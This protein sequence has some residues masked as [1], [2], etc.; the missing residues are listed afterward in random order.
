MEPHGISRA[1][2]AC[3]SSTAMSDL[4]HD[5]YNA[6]YAG[7]LPP[8]G[9]NTIEMAAY[10][11]GVQESSPSGGASGGGPAGGIMLVTIPFLPLLL[12]VLTVIYPLPG[13]MTFVAGAMIAGVIDD[14]RLHWLMILFA[15]TV[16]CIAVFALAM[17]LEAKLELSAGY[18]LVRHVA[19]AAAFAFIVH[20]FVFAARGAGHF[21]PESSLV[22][23]LSL[24][25][26]LIVAGAFVVG[27]FLS[28]LLDRRLGRSGRIMG[29]LKWRKRGPAAA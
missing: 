14:M 19:R 2:L 1:S 21:A 20:I 17:R 16:P 29:R 8:S 3:R 23:R 24:T 27:W 6:G 10:L 25:H 28:H 7:Q 5:A 4:S 15:V 11:R 26:V 13:V 22:D 12:A 9:M 18:R